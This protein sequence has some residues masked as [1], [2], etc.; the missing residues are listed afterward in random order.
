VLTAEDGRKSGSP[1]SRR[2][3]R[4]FDRL[5]RPP[6]L[7]RVIEPLRACPASP[8]GCG[9][10]ILRQRHKRQ[11]A[12]SSHI[13]YGET[14]LIRLTTDAPLSYIQ[15]ETTFALTRPLHL[16]FGPDEPFMGDITSRVRDFQERT[17][18]LLRE[19]VRRLSIAYEWQE[20]SHPRRHH[21]EAD[22][23]RWKPAAL[24]RR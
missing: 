3:L 14:P 11:V 15:Q 10:P 22:D 7:M 18:Q 17:A 9:P 4:N 2:G 16:V 12:G 6:Q 24:S 19:W 20:A 5:L 21:L 8:S 23:L 1:I 13:T